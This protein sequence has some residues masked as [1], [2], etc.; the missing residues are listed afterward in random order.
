MKVAI[1]PVTPFQQNCTLIWDEET[2]KGVVI[3]PGGDVD[4]ILSVLEEEKISIDKILITHGHIDHVGG[5]VELRDA[6]DVEVEGPHE[7]DRML[8]DRVADQAVQFGLPAAKPCEPDR[9]LNEGDEVD[10]AGMSFDVL[11]C[12]GHA[13]GHVVFVNQEAKFAI[14]GDVLFN[15]SIGRTDLPGGDHQTLLNSIRDKLLPLGDD[16]TFLCGHGN[17]STI[18]EERRNNP[19]LRGL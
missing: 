13:P 8:M 17:H 14:V 9:W 11:H 5:A 3:D 4:K 6:L 12:P 10:I 15:G 19:F 2:G 18:G 1:I 16:V 7:A